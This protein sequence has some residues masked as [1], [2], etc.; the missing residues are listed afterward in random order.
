MQPHCPR[1][2]SIHVWPITPAWLSGQMS[3]WIMWSRGD[4]PQ[5]KKVPQAALAEECT[6]DP[7]TEVWQVLEIVSIWDQWN[8]LPQGLGPESGQVVAHQQVNKFERKRIECRPL[9]WW[10]VKYDHVNWMVQPRIQLVFSGFETNT[11]NRILTMMKFKIPWWKCIACWQVWCSKLMSKRIYIYI[12]INNVNVTTKHAWFE[13]ICS[14]VVTARL[15]ARDSGSTRT[16][17]KITL[18]RVIPTLT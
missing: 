18:L 8:A 16:V 2:Q 3:S 11:V 15:H 17:F 1:L 13:Q 14:W 7:N 4:G 12:Y 6:I 5:R 9:P 10:P